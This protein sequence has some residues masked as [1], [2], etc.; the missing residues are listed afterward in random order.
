MIRFPF[1]FFSGLALLFWLPVSAGAAEPLFQWTPPPGEKSAF[2][3]EAP[4][5]VLP[6]RFTLF[7]WAKK[8]VHQPRESALFSQRRD[9]A[10]FEIR[11]AYEA[12]R[13]LCGSFD[14]RLPRNTLRHN[15]WHA[16]AVT[17]DGEEVAIFINGVK[18][19]SGRVPLPPARSGAKAVTAI[20]RSL[21]S[22]AFFFPGAIRS[23]R[24]FPAV[25]DEKEQF[26]LMAGDLNSGTEGP[27]HE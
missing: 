21:Y 10:V 12:V 22:D 4:E 16:I 2:R 13:L 3:S 6:E 15:L 18:H 11:D 27:C 1:Q 24:I 19:W 5:L 25:L 8:P 17:G 14:L 23:V 7:L 26:K 20:G 9:G